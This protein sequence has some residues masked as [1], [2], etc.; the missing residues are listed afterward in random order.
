MLL[1]RARGLLDGAGATTGSSPAVADPACVVALGAAAAA[2]TP[3]A[4]GIELSTGSYG[5]SRDEV[6]RAE[7]QSVDSPEVRQVVQAGPRGD[8][9]TF[10]LCLAGLQRELQAER[11]CAKQME[12]EAERRLA[13]VEA[14]SKALQRANADL[15]ARFEAAERKSSI[16]EKRIVAEVSRRE[17]AERRE[18]ELKAEAA[19]WRSLAR[20]SERRADALLEDVDA[21]THAKEEAQ[22]RAERVQAEAAHA[23]CAEARAISAREAVEQRVAE[24]EQS[25]DAVMAHWRKEVQAREAA[26]GR[27][28]EAEESAAAAEARVQAA[29]RRRNSLETELEGVRELYGEEQA[30][31]G[32]EEKAR[33]EFQARVD[34]AEKERADMANKAA[35][36]G[37]SLAS[38][39]AECRDQEQRAREAA[40][41]ALQH[42]R[43][44]GDAVAGMDRAERGRNEAR[45]EVEEL[46][47]QLEALRKRDGDAAAAAEAG[48]REVEAGRRAAVERAE[49]AEARTSSLACAL[50][51]TRAQLAESTEAA[52]AAQRKATQAERRQTE[53]E[54]AEESVR[55]SSHAL[56][57][58][59]QG[60][61]DALRREQHRSAVLEEEAGHWREQASEK[62]KALRDTETA[63]QDSSARVRTSEARIAELQGELTRMQETLRERDREMEEVRAAQAQAEALASERE[64]EA[65]KERRRAQELQGELTR[66]HETVCERER[67]KEE[68]RLRGSELWKAVSQA[69]ASVSE[70]EGEL[71]KLRGA[72]ARSERRVSEYQGQEDEARHRV[73][74][75]AKEARQREKRAG[76]LVCA[77]LLTARRSSQRQLQLSRALR[78]WRCCA[79]Q[80]GAQPAAED[81]HIVAAAAGGPRRSARDGE[82]GPT[83]SVGRLTQTDLSSGAVSAGP[84]GFH[85]EEG[86]GAALPP[87]RA[88]GEEDDSLTIS[89]SEGEEQA[90]VDEAAGYGPVC[91]AAA[92]MWPATANSGTT[93]SASADTSVAT[94]TLSRPVE[95][96]VSGGSVTGAADSDSHL[97]RAGGDGD[98]SPVGPDPERGLLGAEESDLGG[99]RALH[100]GMPGSEVRQTGTSSEPPPPSPEERKNST[101]GGGEEV[102][103][104]AA[105]APGDAASALLTRLQDG[106][107]VVKHGRRGK[108]HQRVLWLEASEAAPPRLHWSPVAGGRGGLLDAL[109]RRGSREGSVDVMRVREVGRGMASS[110]LQRS[111]SWEREHLY[112][113]LRTPDRTV[114]LEFADQ[115]DRDL[116]VNGLS[117]IQRRL[118]GQG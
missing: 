51:A 45:R 33:E 70:R 105:A 64:G 42:L 112:A 95:R 108:P 109:T 61:N 99:E 94:S 117:G 21:A 30:K 60:L 74:D 75:L 81:T 113:T 34:R 46:K 40:Q 72:L 20:E 71:Q 11:E 52:R 79:V 37:T 12:R 98:S 9:A 104:P 8:L 90:P 78:R 116:L 77:A 58:R 97:H 13:A 2:T 107:A 32:R 10:R 67:E 59:V 63:L 118:R 4:H 7:P 73:T 82:Q 3:H 106:V 69:E 48:L 44:K 49:R 88:S 35:E 22:R 101:E 92:T 31:R 29:E 86:D 96:G 100:Q 25:L 28:R 39:S 57:Q 41:A 55:G 115:G 54:S 24:V 5:W 50:D 68:E 36:L 47:S 66:A 56:N 17:D 76:L 62:G 14:Q 89:S 6:P 15:T 110:V 114:D 43:R 85:A 102:A 84:G 111:G 87:D 19:R 83:S 91:G 38:A 26:E 93:G 18:S 1:Q 103:E 27:E 16:E 80:D 53:A 23:A 65:E